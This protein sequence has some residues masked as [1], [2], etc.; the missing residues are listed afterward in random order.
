MDAVRWGSAEAVARREPAPHVWLRVSGL[1]AA[2]A[3][4]RGLRR[5]ARDGVVRLSAEDARRLRDELTAAVAVLEE[6]E[7][8]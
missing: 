3:E 2:A 8:G 6:A 5:S 4:L 7:A 1:E